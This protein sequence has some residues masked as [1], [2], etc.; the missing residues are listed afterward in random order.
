[1]MDMLKI[2][3]EIGKVRREAKWLL[4]VDRR[5]AIGVVTPK[6]WVLSVSRDR[7]RG[8]R[9]MITPKGRI[10]FAESD[11]TLE[12]DFVEEMQFL[13]GTLIARYVRDVVLGNPEAKVVADVFGASFS[14]M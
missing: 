12:T 8:A 7:D 4:T 2:A 9:V 14:A 3:V 10:A 13:M 6:G 5:D 11:I 1:M